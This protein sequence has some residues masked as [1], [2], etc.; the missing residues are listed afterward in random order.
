MLLTLIIEN[1]ATI[2]R[3]E[4]D[5]KSG[6]IA[7]TGQTGTGKSLILAAISLV[8]GGK[9]KSSLIR[10]QSAQ[11]SIS[12]DF[13][14]SN[15]PFAQQCLAAASLASADNI[16]II[17]RSIT[18]DNKS[19]VYING[20]IATLGQLKDLAQYLVVIY[21][22]HTYTELLQTK[23]QQKWFDNYAGN[24]DNL[25]KLDVL[26][27]SYRDNEKK[28]RNLHLATEENKATIDLLNYQINELKQLDFAVLEHIEDDYKRSENAGELYQSLSLISQTLGGDNTG[29]GLVSEL[30]SINHKFNKLV[31]LDKKLNLISDNLNSLYL[32]LKEAFGDIGHYIG[33]IEI[34]ENNR[35]QLEQQFNIISDLARKHKCPIGKLPTIYQNLVSQLNQAKSNV[36]QSVQLEAQQQQLLKQYQQLSAKISAN[37]AKLA[38]E[39]A[40][41]ISSIMH[42]LGMSQAKFLVRLTPDTT[43]INSTGGEQ[44]SFDISINRGQAQLSLAESASG[45]ELSRINLAIA[46][47]IYKQS[48]KTLIFDEVDIGISGKI[49]HIVGRCLKQLGQQQ[50]VICVTHLPQVAAKGDQ[51]LLVEKITIDNQTFSKIT[52]LIEKQRIDELARILTGVR[53]VA[54]AK[55]V[56]KSL[57]AEN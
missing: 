32:E 44:V 6:F 48:P 56:A 28:L 29:V 27:A 24:T 26:V 35:Q 8:L 4:I 2:E 47:L 46:T 9:T 52:T 17:R 14:I 15:N 36:S 49:A 30:Q 41:K 53:S 25:V 50:Q 5:F 37:R 21:Q 39:F 20:H 22:Q 54:G 42:S 31:A 1:L 34:D 40:S 19:K 3:A 33:N 16:C 11:L 23:V 51:H 13:N 10:H 45:G 38:P 55:E 12:A 7:I 57:R 18:S 43:T